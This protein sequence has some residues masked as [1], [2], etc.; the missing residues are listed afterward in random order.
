MIATERARMTSS[1]ADKTSALTLMH[2]A[3]AQTFKCCS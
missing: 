1:G 2:R 3:R